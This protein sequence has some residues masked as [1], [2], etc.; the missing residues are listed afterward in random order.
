MRWC[1]V[2]NKPLCWFNFRILI[3]LIQFKTA[4]KHRER[5]CWKRFIIQQLFILWSFIVEVKADASRDGV[6]T[7]I[8]FDNK[9]SFAVVFSCSISQWEIHVL[10][11]ARCLILL[12]NIY[13][14][15]AKLCVRCGFN[16]CEKKRA[17]TG[18][19]RRKTE[20]FASPM[21]IYFATV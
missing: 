3:Y 1:C 5:R 2:S 21:N 12:Y 20:K 17:F 14:M 18:H 4:W 11:S 6:R 13:E 7:Q 10:H 15:K 19:E 16:A 8:I 9:P